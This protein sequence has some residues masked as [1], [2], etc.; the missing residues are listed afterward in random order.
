L[1]LPAGNNPHA[2]ATDPGPAER[3][4]HGDAIH[5]EAT[6][7]AGVFCRRVTTQTMLDR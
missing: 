1:A 7:R 4:Q 6:G 5:T 2:A 3:Y